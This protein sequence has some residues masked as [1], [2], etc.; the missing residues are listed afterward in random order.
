MYSTTRP[1]TSSE[2]A[3]ADTPCFLAECSNHV[4]VRGEVQWMSG[5]LACVAVPYGTARE[6][7]QHWD[8]TLFMPADQ[9]WESPTERHIPVQLIAAQRCIN[10]DENTEYLLLRLFLPPI[11]K[12]VTQE[13][14]PSLNNGLV[15]GRSFWR[16]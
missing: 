5:D 15:A 4:V 6:S 14:Q 9:A 2:S 8:A 13:N 3:K 1:Y 12:T 7:R 11:D 16:R 10:A